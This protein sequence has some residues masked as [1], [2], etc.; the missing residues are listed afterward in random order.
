MTESE[1]RTFR[2]PRPPTLPSPA[3]RASVRSPAPLPPSP[4]TSRPH[5]PPPRP[6]PPHSL[7]Q[8]RTAHTRHRTSHASFDGVRATVDALPEHPGGHQ[9]GTRGVFACRKSQK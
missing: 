4:P 9:F 7:A 5:P 3:L 8:H 2:P 1:S 6:W